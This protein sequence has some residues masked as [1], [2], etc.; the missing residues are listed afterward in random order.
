MPR[1][2]TRSQ[3]AAKRQQQ[4]EQ[5]HNRTSRTPT[6]PVDDFF[7]PELRFDQAVARL[8]DPLNVLSVRT[9]A[10]QEGVSPNALYHRAKK[11]RTLAQA[12]KPP[13][14]PSQPQPQPQQRSQ[15]RPQSHT[16]PQPQPQQQQQQRDS[17]KGL[18][19]SLTL[20]EEEKVV[21]HV[22]RCGRQ[23]KLLT[24]KEISTLATWSLKFE[25]QDCDRIVKLDV[26]WVNGFIDRHPQV[27]RAM[28]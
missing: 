1:V 26:K 19:R 6:P 11:A 3:T 5:S 18:L 10:Q 22:L 28:K 17:E 16:Q 21:A 25:V 8:N 12:S 4:Q 15:P 14:P 2:S 27:H 9:I 13:S 7:P 23:F 24:K 20:E